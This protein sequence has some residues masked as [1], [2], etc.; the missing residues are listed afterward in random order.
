MQ[1]HL[2]FTKKK[3]KKRKEK[4]EIALTQN[5]HNLP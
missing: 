3:K 2:T 5:P 1:S 4:Q